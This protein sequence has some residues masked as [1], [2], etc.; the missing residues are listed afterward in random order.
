[1]KAA[2][3]GVKIRP[4]KRLQPGMWSARIQMPPKKRAR[5]KKI[6]GRSLI[7]NSTRRVLKLFLK[8]LSFRHIFRLIISGFDKSEKMVKLRL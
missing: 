6:H 3:I 1:M 8:P 5:L 7:M 4:K 2:P